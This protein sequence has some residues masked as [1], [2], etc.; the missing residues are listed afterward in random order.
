MDYLYYHI[1]LSHRANNIR[2]SPK[3]QSTA[4]AKQ[5]QL[6]RKQGKSVK[7][8]TLIAYGIHSNNTTEQSRKKMT[9]PSFSIPSFLPSITANLLIQGMTV[10]PKRTESLVA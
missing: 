3:Q 7:L 10:T 2:K 6:Q 1:N 8:T 5:Q 4:Q 9:E